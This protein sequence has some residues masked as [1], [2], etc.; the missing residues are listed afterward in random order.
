V[1]ESRVWRR[2]ERR[3]RRKNRS[4]WDRSPT[5]S[6]DST[7]VTERR[8]VGWRMM[9]RMGDMGWKR[10]KRVA[11]IVLRKVLMESGIYP[12]VKSIV[13]G[14]V[15]CLELHEHSVLEM[16]MNVELLIFTQDEVGF[17]QR[18]VNHYV[19]DDIGELVPVKDGTSHCI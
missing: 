11:S 6:E 15:I 1:G 14:S 10:G 18:I 7:G 16:R 13:Q 2:M 17:I 9:L 5:W 3:W 4:V 19:S 8:S 12:L